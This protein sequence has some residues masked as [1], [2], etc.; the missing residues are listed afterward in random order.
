M[1]VST[2]S[3]V[4][5]TRRVTEEFMLRILVAT[6]VSAGMLFRLRKDSLQAT[7]GIRGDFSWYLFIG[8]YFRKKAPFCIDAGSFWCIIFLCVFIF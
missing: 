4:H 5:Y 1:Q 7:Q 6:A 2:L 3:F 8:L